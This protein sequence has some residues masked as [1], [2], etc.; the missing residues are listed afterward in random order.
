MTA[1]DNLK[2]IQNVIDMLTGGGGVFSSHGNIMDLMTAVSTFIGAITKMA[3]MRIAKE[4]DKDGKPIAF[5][6]LYKDNPFDK[7]S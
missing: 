7:A 4:W 3:E 5:Y 6:D 2:N 1:D